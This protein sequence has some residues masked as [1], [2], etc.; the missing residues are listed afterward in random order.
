MQSIHGLEQIDFLSPQK[1]EGIK[2]D[3]FDL[4]FSELHQDKVPNR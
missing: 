4:Q 2:F 3:G 1:L